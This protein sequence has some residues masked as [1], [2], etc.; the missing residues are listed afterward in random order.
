[1]DRK[2]ASWTGQHFVHG[3]RDSL[4]NVLVA[5]RKKMRMFQG[6]QSYTCAIVMQYN[7]I[8]IRLHNEI[9]LTYSRGWPTSTWQCKSNQGFRPFQTKYASHCHIITF[10]TLWRDLYDVFEMLVIVTSSFIKESISITYMF[11]LIRQPQ[12]EMFNGHCTNQ[13]TTYINHGLE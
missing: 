7:M 10:R 2:L 3:W 5:K 11:W 8:C 1:M 12:Y 13:V 4:F 9:C 6:Q